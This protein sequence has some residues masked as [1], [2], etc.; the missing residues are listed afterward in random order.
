[1]PDDVFGNFKDEY[2]F[3]NVKPYISTVGEKLSDKFSTK[4][5]K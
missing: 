2:R 3:I 5:S 1:M 4:G